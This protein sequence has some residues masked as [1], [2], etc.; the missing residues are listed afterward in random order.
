MKTSLKKALSFFVAVAVMLSCITITPVSVS[1]SEETPTS[2]ECGVSGNNVTWNFDSAT[3]TLT[4]SGTGAMADYNTDVAYPEWSNTEEKRGNITKVVIG[5]GVTRIG[6]DSFYGCIK[7]E[8]VV[9][10]RNE[11][12]ESSVTAI[13]DYVFASNWDLTSIVIPASVEGIGN[14]AFN[15]CY[16]LSSLVFEESSNLTTIGVQAFCSVLEL[17]ECIISSKVTTIGDRAFCGNSALK[18]FYYP[19]KVKKFGTQ[20]FSKIESLDYFG[21]YTV[22]ETA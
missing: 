10:E 18:R 16:S 4:I 21:R 19:S 20:V 13:G 22:N 6:N 3:G 15:A 12:G 8:E 5:Y 9:F 1:A 11:N 7:V 14:Y 17:E 2:G